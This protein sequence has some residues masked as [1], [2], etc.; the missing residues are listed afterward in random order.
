M[1]TRDGVRESTPTATSSAELIRNVL[2]RN[3]NHLKRFKKLRVSGQ[4]S[5]Y[6]DFDDTQLTVTRM[7]Q[8]LCKFKNPNNP[9]QLFHVSYIRPHRQH[10][11]Q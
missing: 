8:P 4:P 10:I 9:E 1:A 5:Q 6:P 3:A 7:K 2:Q 11:Q